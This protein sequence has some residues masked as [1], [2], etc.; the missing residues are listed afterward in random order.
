MG[1]TK[2]E[3]V[4]LVIDENLEFEV[5][6]GIA[7]LINAC[8]HNGA[9]TISSCEKTDSGTAYI[10]FMDP[11]CADQFL[12]NAF[13]Y[14]DIYWD[15]NKV[16]PADWEWKTNGPFGPKDDLTNTVHVYFPP[17]II[18]LLTESLASKQSDPPTDPPEPGEMISAALPEVEEEVQRHI[19]EIEK[20]KEEDD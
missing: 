16:D 17:E 2:H 15:D 8:W 4:T 12:F 11:L 19:A 13:A 1:S 18:E 20:H 7:S 9:V 5:D 3:Q 10:T 14:D 6:R